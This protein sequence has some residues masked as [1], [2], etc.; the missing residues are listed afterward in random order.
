LRE[1]ADKHKT[2]ILCA[3]HSRK[4]PGDLIDS[5]VGTSGTTAACDTVWSLKRQND[6]KEGLLEIR[7]REI[8]DAAFALRFNKEEPFGWTVIGEGDQAALTEERR[9][10]VM[11][12]QQEGAMK[13]N[14]IA[15]AL[16]KNAVTIRRLIQKLAFDGTISKQTDGT[17]IV[18][19]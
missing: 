18:A 9:D 5:V 14:A 16:V 12:L 11:L 19:P 6:G 7:G 2:A 17:Y 8:E 3:A 15:R 13:P 4:V 10:I 1:V